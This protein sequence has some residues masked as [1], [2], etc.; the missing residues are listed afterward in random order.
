MRIFVGKLIARRGARQRTQENASNIPSRLMPASTAPVSPAIPAPY[1]MPSPLLVASVHDQHDSTVLADNVLTASSTICTL[2]KDVGE[3]L[4]A[5]PGFK[6]VAGVVV[7]TLKVAE[8]CQVCR[9]A[10]KGVS[11]RLEMTTTDIV[12][13][14]GELATQGEHMNP[15]RLAKIEHSLE[16]YLQL[17]LEIQRKLVKMKRYTTWK[18]IVVRRTALLREFEDYERELNQTAQNFQVNLAFVLCVKLCFSRQ[19][20]TQRD[21]LCGIATDVAVIHQQQRW[22]KRL[23]ISAVFLLMRKTLIDLLCAWPALYPLAILSARRT[24]P[25]LMG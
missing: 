14:L 22:S 1:T 15:D 4:A 7:T 6:A 23:D 18:R 25:S 20:A 21:L 24:T 19:S 17:V 8:E 12:R 16:E 10:V 3:A 2:A 11:T 9:R 13:L 5:V